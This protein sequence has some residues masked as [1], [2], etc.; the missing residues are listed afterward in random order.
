MDGMHGIGSRHHPVEG[1]GL[2]NV[3]R[4]CTMEGVAQRYLDVGEEGEQPGSD[5]LVP[6]IAAQEVLLR[7]SL[8]EC[9]DGGQPGSRKMSWHVLQGYPVAGGESA[10][11]YS[12]A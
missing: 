1:I 11:L 10:V 4:Y 2:A 8:E 6:G 9:L 3:L 7:D 5:C 12:V